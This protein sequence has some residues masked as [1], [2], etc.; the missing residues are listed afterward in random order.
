MDVDV[1]LDLTPAAYLA[2]ASGPLS[3]NPVMNQLALALPR[4]ALARTGTEAGHIRCAVAREGGA[5]PVG[6]AVQTPPWPVQLGLGTAEG[7][8]AL[9][10]PFARA[11]RPLPGVMGPEP[12]ALAFASAYARAAGARAEPL[13]RMGVFTLTAVTPLPPPPGMAR[14]A[15]AA[16]GPLLD[17]W[18]LAF[19]DEAVPS[20]PAPPAGAGSRLVA[21]ARA[22]LWTEPDGTP[23]ALACTGR[24]VDGFHAVG[25]VYTPP[26]SRRC[27][28]ATALVSALSANLLTRGRGCTLF[29]DLANPTANAIYE[30]IGYRRVGT[31]LR[32]RFEH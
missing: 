6:F 21:E 28:A 16:D 24:E 26:E 20:D 23:R 19:H 12:L 14:P 18:L 15:T 22:W 25:P 27:G 7:A 9:G 11:F 29:T 8:A 2:L 17:R 1:E 10:A 32:L 30:R 31:F 13:Q 4:Q 3:A 5:S